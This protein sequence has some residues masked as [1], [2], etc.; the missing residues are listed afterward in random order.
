MGACWVLL[1]VF[2]SAGVL[3]PGKVAEGGAGSSCLEARAPVGEK[4][5][6]CA[7]IGAAAGGAPGLKRG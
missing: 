7:L 1:H 2:G 5:V 6:S 4:A 3:G